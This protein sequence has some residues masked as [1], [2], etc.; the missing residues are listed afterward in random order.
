L[1]V[2]FGLY[3]V[4]VEVSLCISTM[5]Y[6]LLWIYVVLIVKNVVL[7]GFY[8]LSLAFYVCVGVRHFYD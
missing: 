8:Y 2:S 1:L 6:L 3:F 4:I 5:Y 7:L